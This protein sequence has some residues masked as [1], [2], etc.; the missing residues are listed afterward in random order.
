MSPSSSCQPAAPDGR[1]RAIFVRL[2]DCQVVSGSRMV[3]G[4]MRPAA[5]AAV[6]AALLLLGPADARKRT[7]APTLLQVLTP[8]G[9]ANAPAHPDVNIVV[10]FTSSADPATFRARLTGRDITERFRPMIEQGK[11]VGVRATIPRERVKIGRRNNRLRVLVRA[12][13]SSKGRPPRQIVRVRFRPVEANDLPPVANIVPESEVIFPT[14]PLGFDASPSFDPEL[15]ERAYQW[16]CGEAGEASNELVTTYTYMRADEPRTVTLTAS[17]GQLSSTDK[18][19]L[20]S[21]PQPEGVT[22]GTIQVEADGP[23]EFVAVALGASA[24]RS[25][26]ITNVSN[27]PASHLGV[28]I[29]YEGAG[30]SVS[31]ERVDL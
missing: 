27:D 31:P 13:Q 12:Q 3:P 28:C 26:T 2:T 30:F 9:R 22:P 8:A 29:G 10:R 21:C 11:Q 17:D 6:C 24:T 18:V 1:P 20:R 7:K 19:A 15:D 14:V 5:L 23:L 25:F 16:D 4:H